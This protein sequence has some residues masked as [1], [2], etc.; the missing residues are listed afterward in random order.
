MGKSRLP[1]LC[2]QSR[3]ESSRGDKCKAYIRVDPAT[4]KLLLALQTILNFAS[5]TIV[6]QNTSLIN[7]VWYDRSQTQHKTAEVAPL[8]T[9]PYTYDLVPTHLHIS[10]FYKDL[11]MWQRIPLKV[12]PF[13][14]K[15]TSWWLG[16]CNR[17]ILYHSEL[18]F[19]LHPDS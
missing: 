12:E 15:I 16:D 11:K 18:I 19:L 8:Y 17:M 5:L 6:I 4:K 13:R 7:P 10:H 2:K 9:K 3:E 1:S 14:L